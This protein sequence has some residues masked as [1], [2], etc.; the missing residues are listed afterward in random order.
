MLAVSVPRCRSHYRCRARASALLQGLLMPVVMQ[1]AVHLLPLRA[2]CPCSQLCIGPSPPCEAA[3]SL[4]C[5]SGHARRRSWRRKRAAWLLL[6]KA[7]ARSCGT[8]WGTRM[9]SVAAAAELLQPPALFCRP[10]PMP[11][12]CTILLTPSSLPARLH[13]AFPAPVAVAV[14]VVVAGQPQ[15]QHPLQPLIR[16][17]SHLQ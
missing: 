1:A 9:H 17:A 14:A 11:K 12:P 7:C 4:S 15:P 5:T 8:R 13:T 6:W 3:S 10:M 16:K 2:Q